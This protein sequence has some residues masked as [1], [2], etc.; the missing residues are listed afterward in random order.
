MYPAILFGL[1]ENPP[2]ASVE[3]ALQTESNSG[4]PANHKSKIHNNVKPAY[5]I[6]K[7]DAVCF[8]L[9]VI[10]S[11]VGPGASAKNICLPATA[12]CGKIATK[13]TII[14]IPPIH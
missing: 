14:P 13:R 3:N 8:I 10:L 5:I 4:I 1:G 11:S 7:T 6:H 9:G 2:A 12:N